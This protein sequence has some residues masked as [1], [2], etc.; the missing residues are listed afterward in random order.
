[1]VSFRHSMAVAFY[2]DSRIT[3]TAFPFKISER[4]RIELQHFLLCQ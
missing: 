4:K 1:V 3:S 2:L